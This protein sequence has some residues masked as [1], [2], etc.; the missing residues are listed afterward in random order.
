[1]KTLK[2]QIDMIDYKVDQKVKVASTIVKLVGY[3][4]QELQNKKFEENLEKFEQKLNEQKTHLMGEFGRI[5]DYLS[6]F[7]KDIK[8]RVVDVIKRVS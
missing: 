2:A 3:I 1:M 6:N 7:Q 5:N 8:Q 4:H